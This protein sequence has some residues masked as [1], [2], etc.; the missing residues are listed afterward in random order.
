MSSTTALQRHPNDRRAGVLGLRFRDMTGED[1]P[2]MARLYRSTREEEMAGLPWSETQRQQFIQMQ[3]DAQ[4][5]HYRQ[6][7]PAA[8]WL[9]I[10]T[11]G[12][13]VGRL[14]LER[15]PQEVRLIDIALLPEARGKGYGG[16][17]LR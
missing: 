11:L 16:A 13:P 7:Y 4:H 8:L 12:Q 17:I 5:A 6:H 3:F 14:Y 2:F 15:W 9:V 1:M 10:E